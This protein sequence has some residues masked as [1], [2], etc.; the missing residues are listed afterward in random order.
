M[1][2]FRPDFWREG[3]WVP[4]ALVLGGLFLAIAVGLTVWEA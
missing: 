4:Y 1:S 2:L 3:R